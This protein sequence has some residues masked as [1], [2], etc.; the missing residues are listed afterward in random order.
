MSNY[1]DDFSQARF[2][3]H[4]AEQPAHLDVHHETL[5]TIEE[6]VTKYANAV[7]SLRQEEGEEM[8]DWEREELKEEFRL[9]YF[10]DRIS[11]AI[12]AFFDAGYTPP[13]FGQPVSLEQ[14]HKLVAAANAS[15]AASVPEGE[16]GILE[17]A[18]DL[19]QMSEG[20]ANRDGA[21]GGIARKASEDVA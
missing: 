10:A 21:F 13:E 18:W 1:P 2:D 14:S 6:R 7:I 4:F 19:K 17:L 5:R 9:L 20:F 3:D 15:A 8:T 11:V 16:L 12:K